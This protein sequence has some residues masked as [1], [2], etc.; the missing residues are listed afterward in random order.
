[1]EQRRSPRSGL[2]RPGNSH[3]PD[4]GRRRFLGY[5]VAAPTLAAAAQLGQSLTSPREAGAAIPSPPEPSEVYDLNDLLTLAATPTSNLIAVVLN[6]DGT[7]SFD[8]PRA[9]SGQ[10]ITTMAAMLIAEEL[11]LPLDKIDVT[12]A[13][14]RPELVFNQFTAGSNTTISMYNPIRVAAAIARQQLLRAAAIQ[15]DETVTRLTPHLG[16]IEAPGGR[17]LSYGDLAELAA[18]QETKEVETELKPRSQF[19]II[20][21]PRNRI[22]ALDAVTGRKKFAMDLDV[23]DALPTM[24]CR[25]PTIKGTVGSV[26]NVDAVREMPG[27]TDVATIATGVAVRAKTFGQCIDAANALEVSW[28]PGTVDG[29]SDET[30]LDRIKKAEIPLAVPKLGP[31]TGV[32][33]GEFTFHFRNNAALE[34]NTAVADVR[35]DSAEIWAPLQSPI[36]C[37]QQVAEQLGLPVSAVTV[38]VEQAGGAFGRRMFNDVVLEA[39]EASRKMG[40]PVKLMWH[41]TDECRQGRMHPMCTSR[42]RA[43]Y[44]GGNVLTFEQ[45]HTSVATDYTQGFGEIIT[46]LAG[47]VPPLGQGNELGFSVPVFELTVNVPYNFGVVTQLLNETYTYDTFPTSSVRN[48]VNPDVRTAQELI[49][50]QLAAKM[51]K[52]PYEFRRA[53]VDDER[54]RAVLDKAAEVGEWGRAMEP[55]TAQAITVHKE[56]KGATATLVEID[57]RPETVNRKIRNAVTGPRV[58]RV[59][60]AV[61]TG[62]PINPRGL[63]AQMQGGIMDGIAQT[64]TSSLHLKDGTLLEGSWDDYFYTRH[65]NAPFETKVVVMPP[66]TGEPGGAGEFGV[67]SSM[68][69]VACAY[70]RATGTVPTSFPINHATLSFTPKPTVPPLPPSPTNGLKFAY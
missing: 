2:S 54:V 40:K 19:K 34:P 21:T 63:E 4:M 12:L 16:F 65:W 61:D 3:R 13:D 50:D 58:T 14:A 60:M 17:K 8:M 44:A 69:A 15:L 25:P 36:L 31:L 59:V 47:K 62:L 66:T 45:R 6:K 23:P 48:L 32:V 70:A 27:V 7:A 57:C 46:A 11:E 35:P 1:M 39:T 10:G 53:F 33:E 68:A 56:Y 52:D 67:P 41:R 18:S 37:Q 30:V 43:S 26:A 38:H 22:D 29:E 5:L 9:E 20:G 24:I 49:V 64:L 55:N 28:N 51:G 42:I